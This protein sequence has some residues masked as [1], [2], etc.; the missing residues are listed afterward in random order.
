MKNFP[1]GLNVGKN[2][3]YIEKWFIQK[4]G[5]IKFPTKNSMDAYLY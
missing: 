3:D 5:K 4:L 2:T 1:V